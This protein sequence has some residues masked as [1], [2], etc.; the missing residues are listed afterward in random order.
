MPRTLI[1]RTKNVSHWL[2]SFSHLH[3][4]MQ[5]FIFLHFKVFGKQEDCAFLYVKFK[6]S[7]I[8]SLQHIDLC[9]YRFLL[10]SVDVNV[11]ALLIIGEGRPKWVRL[12][13]ANPQSN[14]TISQQSKQNSLDSIFPLTVSDTVRFYSLLQTQPA[15]SD[16]WTDLCPQATSNKK[17]RVF[18]WNKRQRW[19]QWR[20]R[21]SCI[22]TFS[23]ILYLPGNS[24][25]DNKCSV[26]PLSLDNTENLAAKKKSVAMHTNYVSGCTFINS[27]NQVSS[28]RKWQ[29]G[30]EDE[31]NWKK[32][33]EEEEK[34]THIHT[35]TCS[36]WSFSI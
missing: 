8:M 3:F 9:C 24:G 2:A 14:H 13:D 15:G 5:S 33:D 11:K 12:K 36:F 6:Q 34:V 23:F 19:L 10:Q 27:D 30:E 26:I 35:S 31:I 17:R 20:W 28:P 25:L 1:I 22:T 16:E 7:W 4:V 18:Y 29:N 32:E 21:D